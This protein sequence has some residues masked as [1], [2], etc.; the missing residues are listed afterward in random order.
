MW[1]NRASPCG[2]GWH[3]LFLSLFFLK[4]KSNFVVLLKG[5]DFFKNLILFES[6]NQMKIPIINCYIWILLERGSELLKF[7]VST[8][9]ET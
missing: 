4:K 2:G 9:H 5:V 8:R 3:I 6:G 7:V 1:L